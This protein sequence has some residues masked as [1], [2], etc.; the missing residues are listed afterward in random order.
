MSSDLSKALTNA[1]SMASHLPI[2]KHR[3]R[4]VKELDENRVVIISGD[5][6]CGKTT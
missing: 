3:D 6:G 1:V 2:A 5:T 4:I